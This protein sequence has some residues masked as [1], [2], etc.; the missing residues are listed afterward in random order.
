M[1]YLASPPLVIAYALA[2]TMDFDFENQPLGKDSE[3]VDVYLKDLWPSPEEVQSVIDSSI[4]T[5]MFD[6]EYGRIFDGDERW[7]AL[8]T[9]EGAI[10]EWDENSTYVR[11]PN[12][13]DGMTLETVPVTDIEGAGC[14]RSSAT[15]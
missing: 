3:G 12:Y 1:N 14:S 15:R 5:D 4:S 2:G 10:F 9:P 11:K 7:Q 13:F 6:T 8:Q